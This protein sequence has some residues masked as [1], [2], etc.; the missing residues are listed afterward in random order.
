MAQFVEELESRLEEERTEGTGEPSE[1]APLEE[2]P[3]IP[4]DAVL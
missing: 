4:E 1:E 3:I 2:E